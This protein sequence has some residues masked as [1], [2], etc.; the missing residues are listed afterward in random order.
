M[1]RGEW[2]KIDFSAKN[3]Q[4]PKNCK[5]KFGKLN[6]RDNV[7]NPSSRFRDIITNRQEYSRRN[8]LAAI[9]RYSHFPNQRLQI[10]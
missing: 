1:S 8:M 2:G 6:L 10:T 9:K 7:L 5:E 3:L 4:F